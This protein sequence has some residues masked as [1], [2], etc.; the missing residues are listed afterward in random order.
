M[1]NGPTGSGKTTFAQALA[2]FFFGTEKALLEIDLADYT[3]S[4]SLSDLIGSPP[5][6]EGHEDG[7]LLGST[8]IRQ[9]FDGM[10][11]HFNGPPVSSGTC[12]PF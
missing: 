1:F 10:A 7:G 11:Q 12:E 3:E 4:H 5:G 2:E 6:Y 9:P 8:I